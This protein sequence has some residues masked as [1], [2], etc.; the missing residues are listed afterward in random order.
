MWTYNYIDA[1]GTMSPSGPWPALSITWW[2][3][4]RNSSSRQHTITLQTQ[5]TGR[6]LLLKLNVHLHLDLG[7]WNVHRAGNRECNNCRQIHHAQIMWTL[8]WHIVNEPVPVRQKCIYIWLGLDI[9]LDLNFS[10]LQQ[11]QFPSP[12]GSAS[13]CIL[14]ARYNYEA[15]QESWQCTQ[16]NHF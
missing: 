13:H 16:V 12:C 10:P 15:G 7:T 5:G 6:S 3:Q 9:Q 2:G 1:T 11:V 4:D 8:H 14:S